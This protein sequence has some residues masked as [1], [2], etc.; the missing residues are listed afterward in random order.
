LFTV[1]W[2]GRVVVRH[3]AGTGGPAGQTA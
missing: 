2:I 1:V 3:P